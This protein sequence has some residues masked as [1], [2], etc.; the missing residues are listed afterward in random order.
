VG[1]DLLVLLDA[2]FASVDAVVPSFFSAFLA[3][4]LP[5]FL[6]SALH[7]IFPN[8]FS[9]SY[10]R[11]LLSLSCSLFSAPSLLIFFLF[12]PYPSL[13][14]SVSCRFFLH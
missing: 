4:F 2:V 1:F 8:V 5:S 13:S 6:R 14:L 9:F 11:T 3:S 7:T 10:R 12:A